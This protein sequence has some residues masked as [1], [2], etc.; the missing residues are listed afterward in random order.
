M[1]RYKS[2]QARYETCLLE[3]RDTGNISTDPLAKGLVHGEFYEMPQPSPLNSSIRF[4]AGQPDQQ[5][6]ARL[7][8]IATTNKF[9]LQANYYDEEEENPYWSPSHRLL[10]TAYVTNKIVIGDGET[11]IPDPE[12]ILKGKYVNC[13]NY[14][15]SYSARRYPAQASVNIQHFN[16]GD[17]VDI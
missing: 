8:K 2:A 3:N 10:D 17:T 16:L 9:T 15:Y 1:D 4:F 5:A 11:T 6:D 13:H 14:D 12:Y 7:T